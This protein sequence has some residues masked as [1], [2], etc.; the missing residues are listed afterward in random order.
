MAGFKK[1]YSGRM[2]RGDLIAL[3]FSILLVLGFGGW[4]L[5]GG[6]SEFQT[7]YVL[8]RDL[9]DARRRMDDPRSLLWI[10]RDNRLDTDLK[11]EALMRLLEIQANHFAGAS[12]GAAGGGVGVDHVVVK[13]EKEETG[14]N[15]ILATPQW[16]PVRPDIGNPKELYY[17]LE[18]ITVDNSGRV[19]KRTPYKE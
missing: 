15:I 18:L 19:M 6:F 10:V 9:D 17:E 4:I 7:H 3:V 12:P 1:L 14:A 8:L 16:K 5:S 2:S 11:H 13:F